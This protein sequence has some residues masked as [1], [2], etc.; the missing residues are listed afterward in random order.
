MHSIGRDSAND[1]RLAGP[2]ISNLHSSIS[3]DE[4]DGDKAL[5]WAHDHSLNGTWVNGSLI[6][7]EKTRVLHDGDVI[8]YATPVEQEET[9]HD[10]RYLLRLQYNSE[11]GF[12]ARYDL[13]HELGHGAFA[14]VMK[15]VCRSTGRQYAVKI[16]RREMGECHES[17]AREI[18]IHSTL[19]HSNLCSLHEYYLP[20]D[21]DGSI[22]LVLELVE[23][24]DLLDYIVQEGGLSEVRAKDITRQICKAISYIH[25]Q[26]VAHCDVKPENILLSKDKRVAKVADFGL[27]I[28]N[29]RRYKSHII[30]G[31]PD[32]L[33]PE[34]FDCPRGASSRGCNTLRD[35]W[36]VGVTVFTMHVLLIFPFRVP[37]FNPVNVNRLT[38]CTPFIKNRLDIPIA[39]RVLARRID[40]RYLNGTATRPGVSDEGDV[41]ASISLGMK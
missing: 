36:S 38:S 17:L 22:Y 31:T 39:H 9:E 19:R 29:G 6:G 32:Y 33:A 16:I 25:A 24:G 21:G 13:I 4:R 41:F 28:L 35:S 14:T 34:V 8:A 10:Y 1:I 26:G 37:V 27:A 2:R 12:Y 5:I 20:R 15:A 11:T 40:W 7:K 23:G 3:R 30:A 18:A